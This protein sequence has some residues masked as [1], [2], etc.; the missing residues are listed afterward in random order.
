M[1]VVRL[2]AACGRS[3]RATSGCS[4]GDRSRRAARRNVDCFRQGQARQW[5][6]GCCGAGSARS[7]G[8]CSDARRSSRLILVEASRP[9]VGTRPTRS[10]WRGARAAPRSPTASWHCRGQDSDRS[11]TRRTFPGRRAAWRKRDSADASLCHCGTRRYG[12]AR[13]N[14]PRSGSD[15]R[16]CPRSSSSWRG[17]ESPECRTHADRRQSDRRSRRH[18]IRERSWCRRTS[19]VAPS[20]RMHALRWRSPGHGAPVPPPPSE[21]ARNRGRE[22]PKRVS[23]T[24]ASGQGVRSLLP[25]PVSSLSADWQLWACFNMAA[26]VCRAVQPDRWRVHHNHRITV[27]ASNRSSCGIP[28]TPA[29]RAGDRDCPALSPRTGHENSRS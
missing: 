27:I 15:R 23:C 25:P 12:A 21:L 4:W 29:T 14:G 9:P 10:T 8:A 18:R 22:F 11:R 13:G 16:R 1:K 5:A 2:V 20:L 24:D 19:R 3:V 28:A 26:F 17:R 6:R 7:G